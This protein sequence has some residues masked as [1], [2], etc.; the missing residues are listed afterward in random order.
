MIIESRRARQAGSLPDASIP[1]YLSAAQ[2][3]LPPLGECFLPPPDL[4]EASGSSDP[5]G[6]PLTFAWDMTGNG[7][8]TDATGES[9]TLSWEAW[10]R[11]GSSA[12]ANLTLPY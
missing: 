12:P 8:F 6:D 9:P 2:Q 5:D 7:E 11:W 4:R 10:W 1:K 3:Y